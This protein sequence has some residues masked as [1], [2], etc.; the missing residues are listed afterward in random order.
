MSVPIQISHSAARSWR[1]AWRICAKDRELARAL[2][3]LRKS[4]GLGWRGWEDAH[5]LATQFFTAH[6]GGD[7][8]GPRLV[9]MAD[10]VSS[11]GTISGIL[12]DELGSARWSDYCAAIMTLELCSRIRTSG[13]EV[14]FT[15]RTHLKHA[16]AVLVLDRREIAVEFKA[17]HVSDRQRDWDRFVDRWFA[18]FTREQVPVDCLKCEFEEP[19]LANQD[20]VL[21]AMLDIARSKESSFV[22]LPMGAG[23]ARYVGS[24]GWYSTSVKQH[25][26]VARIA[27]KLNAWLGQLQNVD[28]PTLLVVR[29]KDLFSQGEI[30]ATLAQL[31]LRLQRRTVPSALLIYEEEQCPPTSMRSAATKQFRLVL[32]AA[33]GGFARTSALVLNSGA[34][35]TLSDEE[36]DALV[37]P[38]M[39][40]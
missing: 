30:M 26:D 22:E 19:L 20:V 8:E 4:L 23:R 34:K 10:H 15:K 36:C 14:R 33:P 37:G 11:C 25:G 18:A 12:K 2:A 35:H 29:A 1:E 21:Q 24:A 6:Q 9:R 28:G 40:W 32:G 13:R 7:R 5:P 3:F 31:R 38:E 39:L 16:D 27:K 17:L